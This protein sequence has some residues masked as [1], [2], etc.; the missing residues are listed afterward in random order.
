MYVV[1]R[2]VYVLGRSV[3]GVF[4]TDFTNLTTVLRDELMR[5]GRLGDPPVRHAGV[6]GL[7]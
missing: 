1:G 6:W 4:I 2:S 5:V 7:P 3:D